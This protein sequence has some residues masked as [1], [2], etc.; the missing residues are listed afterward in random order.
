[1]RAG[2]AHAQSCLFPLFV[3]P[4][5]FV[6]VF[7]TRTV[8]L[9]EFLADRTNGRAFCTRLYLLSVVCL[10]ISVCNTYIVAKPYRRNGKLSE[11]VIRV[12]RRLPLWYQ[13]V[14]LTTLVYIFFKRALIYL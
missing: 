8:S 11:R 2:I 9:F 10:S 4:A 12:A 5:H 7:N 14:L 13:A 1:V 6:G 3:S